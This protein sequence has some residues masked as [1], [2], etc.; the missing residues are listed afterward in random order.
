MHDPIEVKT[1]GNLTIKIFPDQDPMSPDE[2]QDNNVFLIANH[3]DFY[4]EPP[5]DSTFD[6]VVSDYKKT[7]HIFLLE[8]Y[9]HS[10][11]SLALSK[12]GGFPDR[13]WD[14][15]QLG[16]VFVSKDEAETKAKARTIALSLIKTW[17]QY[18]SGDVYDFMIEDKDGNH[19]DSCGGFYGEDEAMQEATRQ[20]EWHLAQ[21]LK[22][23]LAKKRAEIRNHVPLFKRVAL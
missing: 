6:S 12:E 21:T 20:A 23:H 11:V 19:V 18:L 8:A 10:G 2:W 3:R 13:Q 7:H 9:I 1:L 15:S 22:K 16:A 4:V 14:V 5:K 17:N